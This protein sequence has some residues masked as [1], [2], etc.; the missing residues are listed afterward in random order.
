MKGRGPFF[1]ADEKD[2]QDLV[3]DKH[4][5]QHYHQMSAK[6]QSQSKFPQSI[7]WAELCD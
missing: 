3:H 4:Y 7:V 5:L 1:L 6:C 2:V